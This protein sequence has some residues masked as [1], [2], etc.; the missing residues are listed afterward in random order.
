MPDAC[1][2]KTGRTAPRCR[3]AWSASRFAGHNAA[4]TV[5]SRFGGFVSDF[6]QKSAPKMG[7]VQGGCRPLTRMDARNLHGCMV[8]TFGPQIFLFHS[9]VL[10]TLHLYSFF[11]KKIENDHANP[12]TMQTLS[13]HAGC[14]PAPC[15]HGRPFGCR[16]LRFCGLVVIQRLHAEIKLQNAAG[17]ETPLVN[18]HPQTA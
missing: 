13:I 16:L 14:G 17:A 8:C 6:G 1:L 10:T 11:S 2:I 7:M 3:V 18:L 5:L 12:A 9:M 15:L 4:P